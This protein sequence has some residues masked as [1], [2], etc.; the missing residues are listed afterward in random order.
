MV[1]IT[2]VLQH[3]GVRAAALG[4]SNM[5]NSGGAV[6]SCHLHSS[7]QNKS[8]H[9]NGHNSSCQLDVTVKG[10]GTL[11]LYSDSSP[12]S[13]HANSCTLPFEY[14]EQSGRLAVPLSGEHLQQDVTVVW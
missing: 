1:T 9:G 5:L 4:L 10:H 14:D 3:Q 8:L 2:P 13:V 12:S 7:S 11:L 6:L